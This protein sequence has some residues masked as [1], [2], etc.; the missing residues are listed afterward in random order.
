MFHHFE[1]TKRDYENILRWCQVAFKDDISMS[2]LDKNTYTK[3]TAILISI[4]E[5]KEEHRS[6]RK[7]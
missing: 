5:D 3:I 1:L 4:T 2:T 6:W 7:H